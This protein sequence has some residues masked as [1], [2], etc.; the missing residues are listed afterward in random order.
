MQEV[1]IFRK[2][3]LAPTHQRALDCLRGSFSQSS[4]N[5]F[6]RQKGRPDLPR[7]RSANG[8]QPTPRAGDR[9]LAPPFDSGNLLPRP[10]R[11]ILKAA[12]HILRDRGFQ[13][14]TLQAVSAEAGQHKPS[15]GYYFGNK[16]GLVFAIVQSLL[17]D[18]MVAAIR[19]L[20]DIPTDE[21]KVEIYLDNLRQL[22]HDR[23]ASLEYLEILPSAL[24]DEEMR[25][26]LRQLY[27]WSRDSNARSIGLRHAD[28]ADPSSA[29]LLPLG[30][31]TSA[32][33]DG[34]C[35]QDV[36]GVEKDLIDSAWEEW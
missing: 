3:M 13:A 22:S 20:D 30:V 8:P 31:L 27:A 12:R 11:R 25:S 23:G 18:G 5:H 35:I 16:A 1:L 2:E 15:I 28:P 19:G 36:A 4:A 14:M 6:V 7:R 29:S 10:A 32:I 17:H 21:E 33:L 24:R 26:V 34:L 9:T